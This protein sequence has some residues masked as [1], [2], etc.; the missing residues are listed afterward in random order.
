MT[1]HYV[2]HT[3][4]HNL[5]HIL[6]HITILTQHV[7]PYSN[8][9]QWGM[10]AYK[11]MRLKLKWVLSY[12]SSSEDVNI[13]SVY[14]LTKFNNLLMGIQIDIEFIKMDFFQACDLFSTWGLEL[15]LHMIITVN[16]F[17]VSSLN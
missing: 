5:I 13:P 17:V 16:I 6:I 1:G 9:L 12:F 7:A 2:S 10:V 4:T 14:Q 8:D 3:F 15:N 11:A